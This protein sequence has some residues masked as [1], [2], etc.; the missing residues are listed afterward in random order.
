MNQPTIEERRVAIALQS[1]N[2]I[3]KAH[4]AQVLQC[5]EALERASLELDA[6][7]YRLELMMKAANARWN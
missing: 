1:A 4:I 6:A 7:R 3:A 2:R 5:I